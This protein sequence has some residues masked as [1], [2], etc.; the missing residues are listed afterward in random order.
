MTP[1]SESMRS[2]VFSILLRMGSAKTL[3]PAQS[4]QVNYDTRARW[5]NEPRTRSSSAGNSS[6]EIFSVNRESNRQLRSILEVSGFHGNDCGRMTGEPEGI[7]KLALCPLC[8]T[9][10][11]LLLP[12]K[13]SAV[14]HDKLHALEHFDVV[15]RV[16]IHRDDVSE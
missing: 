9:K 10:S 5:R 6:G 16:S 3:A 15:Q 7:L 12:P 13:D 1:A 11:K 8:P 2:R 14:L 4:A